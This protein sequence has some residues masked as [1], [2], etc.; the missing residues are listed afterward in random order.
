MALT[1]AFGEQ[2][3]API[4]IVTM[5]TGQIQLAA[6]AEE[7]CLSHL[8]VPAR[9]PVDVR[10]RGEAARLV[11]DIGIERQEVFGFARQR[12]CFL[13]LDTGLKDARPQRHQFPRALVDFR[14]AHRHA[15]HAGARIPMAIGAG[16][17]VFAR[18]CPPEFRAPVNPQGSGICKI[19]LLHFFEVGTEELETGFDIGWRYDA[20]LR[21]GRHRTDCKRNEDQRLHSRTVRDCRSVPRT[22][23]SSIQAST[24]SPLALATMENWK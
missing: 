20:M 24:S 9:R 2:R 1:D 3:A 23:S 5:G 21:G 19:V 14:I 17:L 18:G 10:L 13:S 11:G 12:R 4:G 16:F 22:P 15:L 7:E 8:E 6:A